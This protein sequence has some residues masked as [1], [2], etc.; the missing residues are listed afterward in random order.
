MIPEGYIIGMG[1]NPGE[2]KLVTHLYK[3]NFSNPGLPMCRRG[4]NRS[5]GF[6]YSIF[7]GNTSKAGICRI[8][9]KRALKEKDG[10]DPKKRKTKWI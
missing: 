1:R 6:A 8:C 10:V 3:G 4:W 5:D 7:R 2:D 9:L